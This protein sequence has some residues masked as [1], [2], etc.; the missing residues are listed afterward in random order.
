[1]GEES[2]RL[3]DGESAP[4]PHE[5]AKETMGAWAATDR[6]LGNIDDTSGER[7]LGCVSSVA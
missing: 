4:S 6:V 5:V 1:M 2:V 7:L 3:K